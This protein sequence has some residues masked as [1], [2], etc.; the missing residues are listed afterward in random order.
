MSGKRPGCQ[1]DTIAELQ[2]VR[3][4]GILDA[5]KYFG[6]MDLAEFFF[7]LRKCVHHHTDFIKL[8]ERICHA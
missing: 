7:E 2:I 8:K 6:F 5:R 1:W 4:P 3:H